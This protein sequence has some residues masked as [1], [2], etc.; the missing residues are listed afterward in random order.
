M[1]KTGE[2][3]KPTDL[4]FFSI[5]E[6]FGSYKGFYFP[7]VLCFMIIASIDPLTPSLSC[8]ALQL[9]APYFPSYPRY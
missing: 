7:F 1:G 8:R 3:S 2:H 6:K 9:L 5:H 4:F